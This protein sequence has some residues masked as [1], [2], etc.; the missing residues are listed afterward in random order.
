MKKT[1]TLLAA[2]LLA[3][4]CLT[5][6][7]H[8]TFYLD[9]DGSVV[10]SVLE[11]EVRSDEKNPE[12]RVREEQAMLDAVRTGRGDV[13][14]ALFGLG[15]NRVD[16]RIMRDQRPFAILT[17][18]R[19]ASIAVALERFFDDLGCDSRAELELRGG[20]VALTFSFREWVENDSDDGR[21]THAE[22]L[23]EE[24][25]RYR[26]VLTEGEFVE[27]DGFRLEADDTVA[28][29][30]DRS[31]EEVD[32]NEGRARYELV[33]TAPRTAER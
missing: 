33:W 8:H 23:L 24:A 14:E 13:A 31:E 22:V 28:V 5:G 1:M 16:S 12:D 32:A 10:W 15:G 18:A 11:Q 4:G 17:E 25:E 9:P 3:T 29:L 20:L 6:E 7:K 26:F 27:A 2:G 21:R 30:L 19:F